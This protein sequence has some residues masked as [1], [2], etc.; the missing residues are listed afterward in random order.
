MTGVEK[1]FC[2]DFFGLAGWHVQVTERTRGA[3]AAQVWVAYL[4]GVLSLGPKTV[5]VIVNTAYGF[6]S[7][8]MYGL[9]LRDPLIL[10]RDWKVAVQTCFKAKY[11]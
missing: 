9:Q 6:S 1:K 2:A 10:P 7:V 3:E 8:Y 11:L 5:V 4:R